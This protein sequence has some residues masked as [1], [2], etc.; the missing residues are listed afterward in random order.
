MSLTEC[1]Q[2]AA[3]VIRAYQMQGEFALTLRTADVAGNC[4]VICPGIDRK[5]IANYLR[6]AAAE[7]EREAA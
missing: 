5:L 7:L 4:R 6:K 2:Q 3:S 1:D